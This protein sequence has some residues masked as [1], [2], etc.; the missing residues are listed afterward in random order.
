MANCFAIPQLQ[1]RKLF[2]VTTGGSLR[3]DP[4]ALLAVL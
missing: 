3:K 1:A 4:F 2:A